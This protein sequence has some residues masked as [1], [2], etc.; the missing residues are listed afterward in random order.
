MNTTREQLRNIVRGGY[1]LQKLRIMSGN[2]ICANFRVKMGQEPGHATDEMDAAAVRLITDLKQRYRRLTDGLTQLPRRSSFTGD[3]V[4]DTV[5]E[6]ALVRQYV[7]LEAVETRQFQL[8]GHE[9]EAF[10][11]WDE[12]LRDVRGV[13]P[14]MGGVLIS[15]IDIHKA[16]YP[17]SIWRYAGLDVASDG[18]G[19]SRRKEHLITVQ[20]TDAKGDEAERQ[21]ITFNPFLKT[22]L[23]G[24]LATSFL[25]TASPYRDIYDGYKHRLEN[26]ADWAE[27]SK[28]RR[29]NAALR[30]MIKM[31]LIDLYTAWRPLEG[32]PVSRP[33]HEAKL[34]HSHAA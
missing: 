5:T 31:F 1:D 15:E 4:I 17:S 7:E 10:P 14:A 27:A 24:V 18:K 30:Y 19:R 32:L 20:Y 6:L 28:A 9:V 3:G 16:R 8:V 29:H 25:R 13:G 2:R 26:H 34:G 12:F 23:V 11:I 22:K 33:Y 21:S